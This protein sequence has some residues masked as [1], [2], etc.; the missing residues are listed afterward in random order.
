MFDQTSGTFLL[1]GGWV[2]GPSG[3]QYFGDTW[4]YGSAPTASF[5]TFGSGCGSPALSLTNTQL[6]QLGGS[7]QIQLTNLPT[8]RAGA[9]FT[10]VSNTTWGGITLPF[11]LSFLGGSGCTLYVSGEIASPFTT[12]TSTTLSWGF[13]VPNDPGLAG[14]QF[15]NQGLVVDPLTGLLTTN[16]G[17]A[18]IGY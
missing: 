2:G 9:V 17:S 14:V 13:N 8:F 11:D 15:F 7:F 3:V 12:H 5:M 18:T 10:G 6:P 16:G 1:F 4:E